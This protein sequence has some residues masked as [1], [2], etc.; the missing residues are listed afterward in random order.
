VRFKGLDLNL[1]VALDALIETRSVSAAARRLNL[2]Q[3][4]MSAALARLRDYFHDDLLAPDG[5]RMLPTAYAEALAPRLKSQ[6]RGLDALLTSSAGFDPASAERTFSII[7][8]DYITAVVLAPLMAG[9]ETEAPGLRL[10]IQSPYDDSAEQLAQ[11]KA[12]LLITPDAFVHPDHPV[13]LLF[14]ERQVLVGWSGNPLFHK[15]IT[16]ADVFASGH[17]AVSFGQQ[18]TASFADRQLA[19][20][21]KTRRIEASAPTFMAVPWLLRGTRRIAFM[22]ERLA[23]VM[24]ETLP[25][26]VAEVPFDFPAMREMVQHHR[27]RGEDEGLAWLRRRIAAAADP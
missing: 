5:K 9:L 14:E 6:L 27:S 22:H 16:E 12:D 2:S 25:I 3:P 23:R 26:A 10:E 8:T 11:G 18:R 1:L 20:L 17:V 21:G 7:A 15:A 4:A 24:A 19:L 13:E